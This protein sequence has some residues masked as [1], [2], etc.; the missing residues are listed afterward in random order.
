MNE[1]PPQAHS[2]AVAR[3]TD[4]MP[5]VVP[6]AVCAD[7][8]AA[9]K[10]MLPLINEVMP[11]V[12]YEDHPAHRAWAAARAAIARATGEEVGQ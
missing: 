9:C 3:E 7:L 2:D 8:L 1:N 12:Q 11:S 4:G 6:C 5:P 10:A